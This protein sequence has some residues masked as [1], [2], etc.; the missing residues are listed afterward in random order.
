MRVEAIVTD[1]VKPHRQ[2]MLDEAAQELD[3]VEG[4]DVALLRAKG[5]RAVRDVHEPAVRNGDAV[6]VATEVAEN[7]PDL[8]EALLRVHD[9]ALRSHAAHGALESLGVV[10]VVEPSEGA[11]E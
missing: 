1:L 4:D 5:D 3:R 10:K 11:R 7:V 8:A 2:H 6:R 9:P